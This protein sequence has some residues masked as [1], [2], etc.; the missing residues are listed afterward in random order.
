MHEKAASVT[1]VVVASTRPNRVGAGVAS[2][3]AGR[4]QRRPDM[5]VD[6]LDLAEL[7]LPMY[8]ESQ[9]PRLRSYEHEHTKRL[10]EAVAAADAH[11]FVFPEYNQSFS[12]PLK[13]AIDYL[14]H[15]WADKPVGLV[16]YG[17]V[18]GGTRAAHALRP[19]LSSVRAFVVPEAVVVPMVSNRISVTPEGPSFDPSAENIEALDQMLTALARWIP[20]CASLPDPV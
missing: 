7:D 5:S 12:A 13:N 8:N 19:V 20:L 1:Q 6:V 11:V 3:V 14:Y 10:S 2:W 4:I 16:S 9:H 15:E 18:S 17:G